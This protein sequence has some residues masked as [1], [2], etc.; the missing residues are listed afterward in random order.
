MTSPNRQRICAV[1]LPGTSRARFADAGTLDLA[2]GDWVAVPSHAG[3]EP[4]QVVV[5]PDQWLTPIEMDDAIPVVRSLNEDELTTVAANYERA[6]GLIDRVA[7]A[8]RSLAPGLFLSGLR[9]NLAGDTAVALYV[10][11]RPDDID[12]I[13]RELTTAVGT[14]L[15]L[16]QERAGSSDQALHGGG[17]GRPGATRPQTFRELLEQRFEVLRDPEA[18][19]PDGLP[20]MGSRVATPQGSGQLVAID[21]RHWQAT[22]ALD[23]GEEVTVSV[24]DL[25]PPE[26]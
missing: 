6:I 23:G 4:A 10:G 1:R 8:L 24:D 19:A 2:L 20:R 26:E 5:A 13:Q 12:R 16:E 15:L 11:D 17:T 21:I 9:F 14:P 25:R 22:V 3:D 18:F 7:D